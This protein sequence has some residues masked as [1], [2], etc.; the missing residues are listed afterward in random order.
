[1]FDFGYSSLELDLRTVFMLLLLSST[2]ETATDR[3]AAPPRFGDAAPPPCTLEARA[4]AAGP[5][6]AARVFTTAAGERG[7]LDADCG[8]MEACR[9]PRRLGSADVVMELLARALL[10]VPLERG[11]LRLMGRPPAVPGP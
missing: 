10:G 4:L 5:T 1:M 8:A 9:L 6:F 3:L 7:V 2:L 11:V